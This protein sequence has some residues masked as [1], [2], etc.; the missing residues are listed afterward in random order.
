VK[1]WLVIVFAAVVMWFAIVVIVHRRQIHSE[2]ERRGWGRYYLSA[3]T[4]AILDGSEKFAFVSVDPTPRALQVDVN[5]ELNKAKG[6]MPTNAIVQNDGKEYFHDHLVLGRTEIKNPKR[7]GELLAALYRGV[8]K[9]RGFG[10]A[11]FDP[12]HGIVAAAGTN[13]VEL[14]ICFECEQGAEFGDSG[15]RWFLIGKEPRE[16]F[17]RTLQ[18][19]GVPVAKR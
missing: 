19:S 8:E 3:E 13:R 7:K 12:R 14:L 17:N 18:E 10:A 9:Y 2:E 5:A 1:K 11:C 4:R 15:Q 16:L 6:Q